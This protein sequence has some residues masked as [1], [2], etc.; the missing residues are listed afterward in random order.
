[1]DYNQ[2]LAED[3]LQEIASRHLLNPD[4][5][6]DVVWGRA[7]GWSQTKIAQS[8][9]YNPNTISKYSRIIEREISGEEIKQ[10]L[11]VIGL[12]LGASYVLK[13]L[14]K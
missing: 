8:F 5:L 13:E 7:Q 10:L 3:K 1:M 4:I 9:G 11:V 14:T 6:R 12:I 2:H